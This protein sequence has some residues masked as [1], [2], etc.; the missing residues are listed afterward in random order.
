MD[1]LDVLLERGNEAKQQAEPAAAPRVV[2][3]V[4]VQTRP[5]RN[6]DMGSAEAGHYFVADGV[7]VMCSEAG[8]PNG[9]TH[10]LAAGEDPRQIAGRLRRRAWLAEQGE[11]DFNRP[12]GYARLGNA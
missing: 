8:K 12:L 6:G 3:T 4:W 5:P 7:V 1:W 11:S 10:V 2:L 9:K